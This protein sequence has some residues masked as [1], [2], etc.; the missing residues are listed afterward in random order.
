MRQSDEIRPIDFAF[1]VAAFS[2]AA[3]ARGCG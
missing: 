1:Y 2:C 3:D